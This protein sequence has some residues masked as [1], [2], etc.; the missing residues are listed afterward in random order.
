MERITIIQKEEKRIF[1]LLNITESYE[2]CLNT[3]L[4]DEVI[5]ESEHERKLDELN[6]NKQSLRH[7]IELLEVLGKKKV[8]VMLLCVSKDKEHYNARV[9]YVQELS[10]IEFKYLKMWVGKY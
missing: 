8:N 2:E 6:A 3:K 4:Q 9:P 1:S 10:D 7:G 5:S